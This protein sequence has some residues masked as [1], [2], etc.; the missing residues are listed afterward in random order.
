MSGAKGPI[1]ET[2]GGG[3]AG[4]LGD[5]GLKGAKGGL[6]DKGPIGFP[7]S[8]GKEEISCPQKKHFTHIICVKFILRKITTC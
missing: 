6:G 4:D 2:G 5:T 7:G 8:F 1:G 3:E